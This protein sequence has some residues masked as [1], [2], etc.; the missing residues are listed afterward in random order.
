MPAKQPASP[1]GAS[2]QAG[3]QQPQ[4]CRHNV[5]TT[6]AH[7]ESQQLPADDAVVAGAVEESRLPGS[8]GHQGLKR[9]ATEMAEV[10]A[11]GLVGDT[12]VC[13]GSGGDGG[14]G[15]VAATSV[16][17]PAVGEHVIQ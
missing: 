11:P 10:R 7:Q 15:D 16:P 1:S 6:P 2:Q 14:G 13:G 5:T 8:A 17:L 12:D 9:P 3:D 4:Q